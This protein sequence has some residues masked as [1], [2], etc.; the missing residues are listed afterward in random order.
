MGPAQLQRLCEHG[1]VA[2][3]KALQIAQADAIENLKPVLGGV[4]DARGRRAQSIFQYCSMMSTIKHR[5]LLVS[6]CF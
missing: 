6:A 3:S 4:S 1:V 2:D 5:E